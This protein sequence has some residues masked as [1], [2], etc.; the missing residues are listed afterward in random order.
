MRF[1]A[2]G[3]VFLSL[4]LAQ[5]CQVQM[6]PPDYKELPVYMPQLSL[7][8]SPSTLTQRGSFTVSAS[9]T[10]PSA[11]AWVRVRWSGGQ[12]ALKDVNWGPRG[13]A[14]PFKGRTGASGCRGV[15]R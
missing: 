6:T 11:T 2:L 12:L 7:Q 9:T 15:P 14:R 1:L 8:V 3:A 10:N 13:T 4:A 5:T